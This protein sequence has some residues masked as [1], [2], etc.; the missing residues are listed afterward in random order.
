[1][2]G[3]IGTFIAAL[4]AVA[5][6]GCAGL[7]GNAG[8]TGMSITKAAYGTT[9]G[10]EVALYTLKNANGVE[11]QIINY[12]AI[13]TSLKVPDRSGKS[14]N[15][16]LGYD[17]LEEYIADDAYLGCIAGRYA[18]RIANG[19][20]TLGSSE[21]TLAVN[22]P[23]NH[24]HG[25]KAG[26]NKKIWDAEEV[27]RSGAVGVRLTFTSADGEEGYPGTLD[28]EVTYELTKEN[29]LRIDY[30]AE[31]DKQTVVNLTHHGYFNLA[32]AG[33]GDI[34]KHELM[35]AADRYTPTGESMIPTGE[36]AP[37]E[38]TPLDFREAKPIGRD[39]GAD[40]PQLSYGKGFDQNFIL[41]LAPG[42]SPE[43]AARVSEPASGRVMEVLT[44]EPGIQFYTGN[45]LPNGKKGRDGKTYNHRTGFC[46]EAQHFPDSPNQPG[47]PTTVL[48]PGRKY[49]QTTTY[50]FSTEG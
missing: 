29:E 4:V 39:I 13:V 7:T 50:R 28:T 49:S 23:P 25:G 15:I 47:F 2:R 34:L 33:S 6:C 1:M 43:L 31:T 3:H 40:H 26:F 37:V 45:F 22:N 24:L 48:I 18:N 36:L 9:E 32:G 27:R 41:K 44:T 21:Y 38:G 19:R 35:I 30:S 8:N 17:T 5:L 42:K 11:V 10:E 20:F 14:D 12:G 16:V 46:L